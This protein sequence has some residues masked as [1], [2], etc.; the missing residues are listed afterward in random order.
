MRRS[1]RNIRRVRVDSDQGGLLTVHRRQEQR[2]TKCQMNER[3]D[4]LAVVAG[5]AAAKITRAVRCRS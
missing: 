1:V 4:R 3:R 5:N 2:H